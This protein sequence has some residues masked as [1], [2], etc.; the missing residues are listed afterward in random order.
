GDTSTFGKGTVQQ[1]APLRPFVWPATPTA[2]NDPGTLKITISKFYR[3]NGTSTQFKG[4]LSDIV[5]PDILNYSTDIGEKSL[6]YPLPWDTTNAA[7][8]DKLNM[9]QP[10]LEP[11]RVRSEARVATN[12]DFNYI[13]QDITE[14]K[15]LQADRTATLNEQES[16]KER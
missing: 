10:Y 3:V 12:Q 16:L 1:L 15:K 14:F 9:A 5:L 2:T 11:L 8:Y 6:D 13:R 4:V 7:P